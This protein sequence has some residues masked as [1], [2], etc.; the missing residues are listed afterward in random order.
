MLEGYGAKGNLLHCWWEY[1]LIEPLWITEW[2]YLEKLKIELPYD[3]EIS[4]L[5]LLCHVS[6]IRLCVTPKMAAHQA[7]P[8]LGFSRQEH[9]SGLPFPTPTHGSESEVAQ[10]CLTL[11]DHMDCSLPGSSIH[12]IFPDKSTGVGCHCLLQKSHYWVYMQKKI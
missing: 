9:W 5:L 3:P 4:L 1:K 8:S 12:G 6:C 7:S 10:S 2:R 11:R